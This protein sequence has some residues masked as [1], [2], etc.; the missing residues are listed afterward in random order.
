MESADA[1]AK[2]LFE[3]A[4]QGL[5]KSVIGDYLGE[6]SDFNLAVLEEYVRMHD[7]RL[8]PLVDALRR[9]LSRFRLA[10]EAQK[11]DRIMEWV[12]PLSI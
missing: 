8:V 12:I 7:F 10:G 9:F 6:K 1:V 5:K 2:F 11:I 4:Q 3:Y